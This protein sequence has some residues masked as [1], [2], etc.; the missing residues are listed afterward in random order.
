MHDDVTGWNGNVNKHYMLQ[1]T[2]PVS[3]NLK[4]SRDS[5]DSK[6]EVTTGREGFPQPYTFEPTSA[7]MNYHD[8]ADSETTGS[9]DGFQ[10]LQPSP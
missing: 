7:S 2:W 1:S 10:G 8:E 3:G 5:S 4:G 6:E 9:D